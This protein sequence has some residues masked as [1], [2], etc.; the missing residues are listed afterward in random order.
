[1]AM[2]K[3][4]T[5]ISCDIWARSSY[6]CQISFDPDCLFVAKNFFLQDVL[7]YGL[8]KADAPWV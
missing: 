1:M 2:F 6:K 8:S 5:K 3:Y 7:V 4:I